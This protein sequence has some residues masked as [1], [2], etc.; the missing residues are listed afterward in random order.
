MTWQEAPDPGR[1]LG[2]R[3]RRLLKVGGLLLLL[4]GI[5]AAL[6]QMLVGGAGQRVAALEQEHGAQ[7]LDAAKSPGKAP[8][9]ESPTF[10]AWRAE[11][12]LW[13]AARERDEARARRRLLG[14]AILVSCGVQVVLL[15]AI[16]VRV[17]RA[18]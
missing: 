5:H 2:V 12:A 14:T 11:E 10:A 3:G 16:G 1:G 15:L 17:L 9:V 4:V 6:F 7:A 18:R 8:A 13:N